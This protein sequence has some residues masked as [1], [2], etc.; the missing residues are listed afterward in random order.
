MVLTR[1]VFSWEVLLLAKDRR[2]VGEPVDAVADILLS[3]P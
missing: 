1:P 2:R 3:V